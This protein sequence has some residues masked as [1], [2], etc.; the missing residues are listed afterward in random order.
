[1]KGF[2][3]MTKEEIIK[4]KAGLLCKGAYVNSRT[5]QHLLNEKPY[6]F[7]KGFIH[8]VNVKIGNSNVNVSV[9][10]CYSKSSQFE[11]S[12]PSV[13]SAFRTDFFCFLPY[14]L[15]NLPDFCENAA[16]SPLK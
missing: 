15:Q 12:P 9:A 4:L 10:E 16:L 13:L 1:M 11:R 8:A 5:K 6:F 14:F 2:T 3:C 7:D